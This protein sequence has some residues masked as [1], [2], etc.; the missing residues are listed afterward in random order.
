MICSICK[1]NN[2]DRVVNL[3]F[4]STEGDIITPIFRC[5]KCNCYYR[6]FYDDI[7][8][9]KHF[10]MSSYTTQNLEDYW[11]KERQ[12]FFN[13]IVDFAKKYLGDDI[14]DKLVLDVG[15]SYGHLL[16]IFR[17]NGCSCYGIEPVETLCNKVSNFEIYNCFYDIPPE[18]SFDIITIID[19]LY[20]SPNP[21]DY[22]KEL[23]SKLK[24]NGVLII[25]VTNRTPLLDFYRMI[26]PK[27]INNDRFGDQ[28]FAFSHKTMK[29]IFNQA[30][31]KIYNI[32]LS[33]NKP[34]RNAKYWVYYKIMPIISNIFFKPLTP[35]IIYVCKK[36]TQ[37]A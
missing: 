6:Y 21:L 36:E 16:Q 23:S 17:D 3:P 4:Y 29:Y 20:Y 32:C 19:S 27:L 24:P 28:L 34:V 9:Q 2:V 1:K 18:L 14:K 30:D 37:S 11:L 13:Q 10:N 25:R 22:L 7:D 35:G 8:L 31:L 12:T 33:E 26:N 5:S 15:C